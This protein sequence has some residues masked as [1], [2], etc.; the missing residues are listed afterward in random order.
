MSLGQNGFQNCPIE[1]ADIDNAN[2]VFGPDRS[3]IKGATVQVKAK[4]TK[5]HKISIPEDF[6]R[7]HKIVTIT[8]DVMFISSIP[9]L[10][11]FSKKVKLGTAEF[12]PNRSTRML[13]KSLWKVLMVYARGGFF[14]N[15]ALMDKEFDKIKYIIPFLEV[16]ITAARENVG[17]I[18]RYLRGFQE[19]VQCTT[20]DFQ[21]RFIPTM[22][23]I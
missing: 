16:N 2:V 17:K 21:V 23:M 6:Y 10:V 9:F 1:A 5:E 18:E 22:V 7:L 13:D 14:V 8:A 19:R 15:L 20:S 4:R 12:V 3:R 11:T